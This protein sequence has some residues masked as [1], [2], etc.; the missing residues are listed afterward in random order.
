MPK[1]KQ[2]DAGSGQ[3]VKVAENLYRYQP[4]GGYYALLK[5]GG[6][7][8]RRSLKTRDRKLAERRL[9]G[10]REKVDRIDTNEGKTKVEFMEAAQLWL[11]CMRPHLTPSS[12]LRRQTSVKQLKRHFGG[13]SVRAI[14]C[15]LCN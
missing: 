6:K 5:G 4:S 15:T 9:A 2:A 14:T 3:F 8:I 10:L 7:Q 11:D 13:H 1:T 12:F